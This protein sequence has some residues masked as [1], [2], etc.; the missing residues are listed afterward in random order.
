MTA[1]SPGAA[2]AYLDYAQI[3]DESK[4]RIAGENLRRL[5][6]GQGPAQPAPGRRPEDPIVADAR[7]GRPLS[8]LTIDAHS[9]VLHAGGQTAGA[10]MTMYDGG[11]EGVLEVADWSGVDRLAMMSWS[12]PTCTDAHEGNEI[13]WEAIR[14]FGDRIA[15]IAV[16]DPSHMDPEEVQE[17]IWLRHV[18]QGFVG[19]KPYPQM[20]LS[21]EDERF[22]PWWEFGN[23]HR[24]FA[25]DARTRVGA[26]RR[27]GGG[28][29]AGRPLPRDELA[30][31][32]LGQHDRLRRGGGR[33]HQGA[34]QRLRRDHLH[35][36]PQPVRRV[37]GRA[38]GGGQRRLR[39]GP[40]DERPAAPDGVGGLGRPER[41]GQGRRCWA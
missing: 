27:G 20:A 33:L 10:G 25:L 41:G 30:H 32:P 18:E 1:R 21:Y 3:S 22:D 4:R 34:P 15:G 8:A 28:R 31:S 13:V 35:L 38:G 9:H 26:H 36:G 19:M 17:E 16:V 7:E 40:A 6:K 12:G 5:L 37:P 24:L 2:R 14:R 23:E 39:H 29:P 11:A